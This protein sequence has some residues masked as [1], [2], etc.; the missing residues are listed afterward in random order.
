M[1]NIFPIKFTALPPALATRV[2]DFGDLPQATRDLGLPSPR[3][4]LVLVGGAGRMTKAD[5]ARLRLLF[6]EAL[7]PIA[8]E[9]GAVI[10]DGGMVMA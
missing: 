3:P 9:L 7:A 6:N 8:E 10:V 4:V 1:N 2:Q 5:L